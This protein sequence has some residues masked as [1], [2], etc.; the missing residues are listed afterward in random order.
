MQMEKVSGVQLLVYA[1][2]G[3]HKKMKCRSF[4]L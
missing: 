3:S 2:V 4:D 1:W